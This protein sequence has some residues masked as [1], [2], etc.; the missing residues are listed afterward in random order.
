MKQKMNEFEESLN[1]INI[2]NSITEL[3]NNIKNFI[4]AW[5]TITSDINILNIVKYGL[6]ID[7]N[8]WPLPTREPFVCSRNELESIHIK[9]EI[10]KL[11]DKG[12]IQKTN[13][14]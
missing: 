13:E 3:R 4:S 6:K 2:S 12:V 10:Q 11:I 7:F 8:S 5:K 14:R 1:C 9:S